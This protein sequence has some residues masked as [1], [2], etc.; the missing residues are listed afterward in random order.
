M[1]TVLVAPGV[2]SA[3]P[4]CSCCGGKAILENP[5]CPRCGKTG[6]DLT[7]VGKQDRSTMASMDGA[8]LPPLYAYQCQCGMTFTLTLWEER[9][10]LPAV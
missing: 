1:A 7:L 6:K 10:A 5:K 9:A 2:C 3:R 8:R 4:E